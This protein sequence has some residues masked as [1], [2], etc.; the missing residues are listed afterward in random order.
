M[1]KG[2]RSTSKACQKTMTLWQH[3]WHV[4]AKY[5]DSNQLDHAKAKAGKV[6]RILV[7]PV[8]VATPK[9]EYLDLVL[10]QEKVASLWSQLKV[11]NQLH[12]ALASL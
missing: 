1:S 3:S 11:V 6:L 5:N 12:T 9:A 7:Q 4:V 8:A 10:T 2:K